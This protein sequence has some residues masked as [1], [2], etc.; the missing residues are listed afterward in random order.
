MKTSQPKQGT[1][2]KLERHHNDGTSG[3]TPSIVAENS[4]GSKTT[5]DLN[6]NFRSHQKGGTSQHTV[7]LAPHQVTVSEGRVSLIDS[8]KAVFGAA[9]F[10]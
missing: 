3:Q 5:H 7:L 1:R 6:L 2:K 9:G 4:M 10:L 8:P